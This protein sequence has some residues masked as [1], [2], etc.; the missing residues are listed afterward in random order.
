MML[1]LLW[2]LTACGNV[3]TEVVAS[4]ALSRPPCNAPAACMEDPGDLPLV[5][6]GQRYIEADG[7]D[8]DYMR[9]LRRRLRCL[10][11]HIIKF[12]R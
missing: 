2:L 3:P 11:Q 9:E 8:I 10:Q 4:P 12:C 6:P 7:P 1:P 5:K